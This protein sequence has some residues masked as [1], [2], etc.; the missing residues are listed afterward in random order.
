MLALRVPGMG[1]IWLLIVRGRGARIRLWM[2]GL[3]VVGG[4]RHQRALVGTYG[5]KDGGTWGAAR[6][7]S[8]PPFAA[9]FLIYGSG[10]SPYFPFL[11]YLA[12]NACKLGIPEAGESLP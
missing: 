9:P 11:R 2:F 7:T 10:V 8:Y 3:D 6:R 4:N 12:K 1:G 5:M